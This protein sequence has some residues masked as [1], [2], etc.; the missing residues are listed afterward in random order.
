VKP[1]LHHANFRLAAFVGGILVAAA[2]AWS[3]ENQA[4]GKTGLDLERVERKWTGDFDGM[5]GRH[6]I[7]ALVVYSKTFYFLDGATQRGTST[8][9][10][11]AFQEHVNK[12][13]GKKVRRVQ[14]LFIPVARDELLP[15][16]IEGRGDLAVANLTITPERQRVVAFSQPV[17]SGIKELVVTGPGAPEIKSTDDLAGKKVLVRK[18]SSYYES[19][20]TLNKALRKAG[21]RRVKIKLAPEQLEDEDL[22]EMV[23]AGLVP[24]VI[25]DSHK[26]KFWAQILKSIKVHDDVAVR[27][28]GEI[29]WA[30]RKGSPKLAAVVND[31]VKRHR[32]GTQFGNILYRRYLE[33]TKWVTRATA[34]AELKK[35][36][37]TLGL[38]KKYA[39]Q[40]DFDWLMLA[41]LGYQE[42]RLDQSVRSPV[43]AIGVMQVMPATG[44]AMKVG[45]VKQIE[46]N[47]HAGTKYL[48]TLLDT[49]FADAKMDG[50]NRHLF[51]FASY[52]AGP[53]RVAGLRKEA[54]QRGLDPDKWFGSVERVAAEKIGRET[55]QYVSN[56]YKYYVAYKLILEERAESKA[57]RKA[58]G[59]K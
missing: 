32:K 13:L 38:F 2:S 11:H 58:L 47:I 33:N 15:A 57:A 51:A 8:D 53:T 4:P 52:N 34:D 40:Y 50:L 9:A 22:L 5:V 25:V 6:M 39:G 36:E 26:A 31:F 49:Y 44:A 59:G 10:L 42:S 30:F 35:F 29:A 43:G 28:G 16:L 55:V 3:T 7:R 56:I 24:I 21:K 23:N 19:L 45:N 41:A 18:S 17:W 14:V 1:L 46:P 48:R 20:Q 54:E 27:E 12:Q 37:R